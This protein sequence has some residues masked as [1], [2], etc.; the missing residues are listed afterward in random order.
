MPDTT[1]HVLIIVGLAN[2]KV[3]RFEDALDSFYKLH[4]IMRNSAQVIFQ[5]ADWYPWSMLWHYC[6]LP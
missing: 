6:T 5:I 4:A 2:K 1:E 3:E